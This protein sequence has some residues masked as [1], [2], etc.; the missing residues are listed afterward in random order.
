MLSVVSRAQCEADE[1]RAAVTR[2]LERNERYRRLKEEDL[3]QQ[4]QR[5]DEESSFDEESASDS[6]SGH[7]L[8]HG[9]GSQLGC[10]TIF[11]HLRPP[12]HERIAWYPKNLRN[13]TRRELA[14][15]AV[16]HVIGVTAACYASLAIA[17]SLAFH[18]AS[19][20][21]TFAYS[22]YSFA[23]LGMLVC[24]LFYNIGL[25]HWIEHLPKLA[26]I[27][28]T[29]IC[30]LIAGSY[31]PVMTIACSL[32]TLAFVWLLAI[33]SI[34][35]KCGRGR[36]DAFAVHVPCFLLM[37]WSC[38]F[39][40]SSIGVAWSPEATHLFLWGGVLYTVRLALWNA[41]ICRYAC[42]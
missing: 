26:A 3:P 36:L 40:W 42:I 8:L 23:L 17:N 6:G 24:S 7:A 2:A 14:A 38:L 15:D 5:H 10:C 32:P 16:V 1:A 19:P 41:C 11:S 21:I 25:G 37:G 29:G 28:H 22:L 35:I 18:Q 12:W 31:T 33:S 13:Y 20:L 34:L 9:R 39:V 27:D 4:E 30:L